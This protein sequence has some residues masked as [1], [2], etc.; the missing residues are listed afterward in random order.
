M[1]AV[2]KLG[3]NWVEIDEEYGFG[4]R[5]SALSIKWHE[6]VENETVFLEDGRW[7][8]S[9]QSMKVRY[10]LVDEAGKHGQYRQ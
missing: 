2:N 8:L 10:K 9:D 5:E 3:K 7:I 1:N 4:L 6:M